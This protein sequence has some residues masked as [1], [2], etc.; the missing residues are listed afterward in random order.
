MAIKKTENFNFGNYAA[1]K[2]QAWGQQLQAA[3]AGTVAESGGCRGSAA[4]RRQISRSCNSRIALHN[5]SSQTGSGSCR[6]P[7]SFPT[8]TAA[9][10]LHYISAGQHKHTQTN[11]TAGVLFVSLRSGFRLAAHKIIKMGENTHRETEGGKQTISKTA[12]T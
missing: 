5:S 6:R 7:K 12:K 9:P 2:F 4:R 10:T 1:N 11:T 3:A 8:T